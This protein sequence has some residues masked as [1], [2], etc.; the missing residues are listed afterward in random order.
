MY[1]R[2]TQQDK[3]IGTCNLCGESLYPL[4]Q[5]REMDFK[6]MHEECCDR[7]INDNFPLRNAEDVIGG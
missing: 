7:Y 4:D 3:P 5:V 1:S 6:V 2:D